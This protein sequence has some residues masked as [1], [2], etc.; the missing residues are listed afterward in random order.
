LT[1][2]PR[3]FADWFANRRRAGACACTNS[4][5][6]RWRVSLAPEDVLGYLFWTRDARPLLPEVRALIDE[7]VPV[8]FQFTVTAYGP[9]L[10][11]NRVALADQLASFRETAACLPA[12]SAIQLR[13]DPIL[14]G[15]PHSQRWHEEA[16]DHV[17]SRLAGCTT[18]V[19]TS[20]CEP[21]R[22]VLSRIPADRFAF[23]EAG[24][25]D[26]SPF[27]GRLSAIASGHGMQLR[28]CSNPELSGPGGLPPAQC[29]GF[30]L[31]AAYPA[32]DRIRAWPPG[33]SRPGCRCLATADIGMTDT[34]PAGCLYCYA[35]GAPRKSRAFFDRHDPGAGSL[36]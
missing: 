8:A 35:T 3:F 22:K 4:F 24:I 32:A 19:N 18:V 36:R 20:L 14:V 2:I 13:Y 29:C 28:V 5:G 11:E 26:P 21:Y 33:P 9:D 6:G 31:F 23:R 10:E 16:L 17:C 1:D 12:T 30:E 15:G 25:V 7:G 34:C 27:L